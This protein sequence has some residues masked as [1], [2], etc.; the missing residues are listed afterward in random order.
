ML[1]SYSTRSGLITPRGLCPKEAG[2]RATNC[3]RIQTSYQLNLIRR[4]SR[5]CNTYIVYWM[6]YVVFDFRP[7]FGTTLVAYWNV[8]TGSPSLQTT[9]P[10]WN[11]GIL[12]VP[13]RS[14]CAR[15]QTKYTNLL[16]F[17]YVWKTRNHQR[18]SQM[19]KVVVTS[20]CTAP[21][22]RLI[23]RTT[24]VFKISAPLSRSRLS[25]CVINYSVVFTL[26]HKCSFNGQFRNTGIIMTSALPLYCF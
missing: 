2:N 18:S 15:Q 1:A 23:A 14:K 19:S 8:W 9:H 25:N 6:L 3:T 24:A 12:N 5:G 4:Y 13:Q 16:Y 10:F 22:C 7:P 17:T 20:T 21:N 26:R 11:F